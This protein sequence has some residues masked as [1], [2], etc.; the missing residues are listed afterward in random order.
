M[1]RLLL[2]D[3]K[4]RAFSFVYVQKNGGEAAIFLHIDKFFL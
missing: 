3:V 1:A 4:R 2:V